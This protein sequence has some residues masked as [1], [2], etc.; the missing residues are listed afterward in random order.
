[1]A[2]VCSAGGLGA[3]TRVLAP[4]PADL[5]AAV[6]VLQHLDPERAS[7]LPALLHGRTAM[8][9]APATDG[10]ALRPGQVLVAPPG[11]HTLVTAGLTV[12]LIP[13]GRLPPY[14]PSAD[15]LLTTLAIAAGTRVIAVVLSGAG[16]DAATGATAV[17]HFGGT[18]VASS[19]ATSEYSAM[20]QATIGRDHA[21]NHIVALDDVAGLL[22]RLVTGPLT[23][24]AGPAR[25]GVQPPGDG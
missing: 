17:H 15:L 10:A 21:I 11:Q 24:Q 16:N 18:V 3:L 6:I 5:P 2:L 13:S 20:P 7:L 12:A 14:R 8:P 22:L 4:L 25:T 19:V 1:V 9:V 23:D